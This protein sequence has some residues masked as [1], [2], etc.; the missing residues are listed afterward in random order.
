MPPCPTRITPRTTVAISANDLTIGGPVAST[1]GNLNLT[2]ANTVTQFA[3]L[4]ANGA[5]NVTVTTMT[6]AIT[7]AA[8]ATTPSGT[9]A[10]S[11][12]AG[13]DVTLGSLSTGGGVNVRA[14][15]SVLSAAGSGTNVTAG[16]NSMLQAF[17]GVVGMSARPITV[18]VN[19]GTVSIRA[20]TSVAGLSAFLTGTVL[21]SN[22]LTLL[23]VPPGLV[24]FDSCPVPPSNKSFW[25]FLKIDSLVQS[26]FG[27]A[28][29]PSGA[30]RS[31]VNQHRIDVS[32]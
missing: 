11:Y 23:N 12:T 28:L 1:G 3:N 6:G 20:T 16:A 17:N 9:G 27:C 13:T 30:I 14:G 10:I 21:P 29:V 15:G 8:A 5:N 24:C 22:A 26:R 4:T 7:M 25:W 32:P 19:P 31:S 18:N 2:G